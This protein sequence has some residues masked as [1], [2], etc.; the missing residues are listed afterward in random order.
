MSS[1]DKHVVF[2]NLVVSDANTSSFEGHS[3]LWNEASLSKCKPFKQ[4]EVFASL[5]KIVFPEETA[6]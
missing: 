1:L 5:K 4:G 6:C 3:C 2:M